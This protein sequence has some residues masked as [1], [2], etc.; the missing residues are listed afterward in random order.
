MSFEDIERYIQ[1]QEAVR[2][3]RQVKA[4]RDRLRRE[5]AELEKRL[6]ES[7]SRAKELESLKLSFSDRQNVPL[8]EVERGLLK[9]MDA[10]VEERARRMFESRF[11]EEK[12]HLVREELSKQLK[13]IYG[14]PM[15]IP[16]AG[17][18]DVSRNVKEVVEVY[19]RSIVDSV[20]K[21]RSR[22]P[23]F[24][25]DYYRS[26]VEAEVQRRLDSIFERRVRQEVEE[27]LKVLK[28][29]AWDQYVGEKASQLSLSLRSLAEELLGEWTFTCDKC[30]AKV[31]RII[32]EEGLA[33]LLRGETVS[34]PE[35][36]NPECLNP[37][38][39]GLVTVRH[40]LPELSL[41]RLLKLYLKQQGPLEI[42]PFAI[43]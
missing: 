3:Y 24:F 34:L 6:A 33:L 2:S 10:E 39:F 36:P 30:G 20:L 41:S 38:L 13:E 26:E 4:E 5:K 7:E 1:E 35:C 32:D 21:D 14:V 31:K 23:D 19:A 8:K 28:S 27:R 29:V 42:R 18:A 37:A 15:R 40:R 11:E 17:P 12:P 25:K 16:A 43:K 22:W 9:E